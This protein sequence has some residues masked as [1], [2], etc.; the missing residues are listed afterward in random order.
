MYLNNISFDGFPLFS[1]AKR[2]LHKKWTIVVVA[3]AITTLFSAEKAATENKARY[4]EVYK[5]N[6]NTPT[7]K[8]LINCFCVVEEIMI[9]V[10][11]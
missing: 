11:L 4:I 3:K 9:D 1:K 6:V 7:A 5:Q 10:D 8:N 2:L